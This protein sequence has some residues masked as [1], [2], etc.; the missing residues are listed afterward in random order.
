MAILSGSSPSPR[1]GSKKY[2]NVLGLCVLLAGA[3]QRER[4]AGLQ[5]MGAGLLL[6]IDFLYP[7][8]VKSA[9][10][11]EEA[12]SPFLFFSEMGWWVEESSPSLRGRTQM[13]AYYLLHL[14]VWGGFPQLCV[15]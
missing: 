1:T 14:G 11:S 12:H 8:H 13:L 3:L 6:H 5:Y 10:P 15:L 4:D 7:L 9:L 2:S